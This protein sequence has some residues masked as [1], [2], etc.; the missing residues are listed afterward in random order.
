MVGSEKFLWQLQQFIDG[1]RKQDPVRQKKLQVEVN[2]PEYLVEC[3]LDPCASELNKAVGDLSLIVFYYL[4]C[5]GEYTMKSKWEN[6][7]QTVQFKM[8][9]VPF[10]GRDKWGWL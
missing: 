7:N 10:F 5:I 3:G 8:G 9:D 2:I 1:W 6:T 4:L